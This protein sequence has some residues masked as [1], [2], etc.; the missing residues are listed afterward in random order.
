MTP[1]ELR[2]I[3]TYLRERVHLESK[4]P[5][6]TAFQGPTKDEMIGAGLNLCQSL[7]GCFPNII[8]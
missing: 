4:G 3:M 8:N 2:A 1:E 5:V 7:T 6:L